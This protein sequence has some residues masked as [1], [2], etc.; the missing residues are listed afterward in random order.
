MEERNHPDSYRFPVLT[1]LLVLG[2]LISYLL[3]T[4]H[5]FILYD[6]NLIL[7]GQVWRLVTGVLVHFSWSHLAY[8]TIILVPAGWMVER[9][10]RFI[11]I[12]LVLL[13]TV[14]SSLYFLAFMPDMK[15]YGGLSGIASASVAYLC[16]LSIRTKPRERWLWITILVLFAAKVVFE[17][18]TQQS[19]FVAYSAHEIRVVPE[20]HIIGLLVAFV[21]LFIPFKMIRKDKDIRL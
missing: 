17:I 10:R 8:N 18:F 7:S 16:M 21:F 9:N 2:G 12:W 19:V 3:P 5:S 11:F 6:R 14:L 1:V 15:Q 13:T 20:T 4:T